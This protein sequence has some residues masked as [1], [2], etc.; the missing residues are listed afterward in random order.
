LRSLSKFFNDSF[1]NST[2]SNLFI[3]SISFCFS[4]R[5]LVLFFISEFFSPMREAKSSSF[6]FNISLISFCMEAM[7]LDFSMVVISNSGIAVV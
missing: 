4:T 5:I 2:V 6:G 1:K 3:S 7:F